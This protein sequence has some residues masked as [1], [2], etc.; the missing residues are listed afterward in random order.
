[1]QPAMMLISS[2]SSLFFTNHVTEMM[3]GALEQPIWLILLAMAVTPAI[4]EELVFR[5]YLQ[6]Q[7]SNFPIKQAALLNGL[8]FGIIHLNPQQFSYAFVLGIIFAY[9]VYYTRSIWAG[10]LPHFIF[11]ASQGLLGRWAFNTAAN[12]EPVYEAPITWALMESNPELAGVIVM[13]VITLF[14]SPIIISLFVALVKH[15][16]SRVEVPQI[17]QA[18]YQPPTCSEYCSASASNWPT[19]YVPPSTNAPNWT[20]PHVPP[21]NFTVEP[22]PR[23]FDKFTIAVIAIFIVFSYFHI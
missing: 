21:D 2:I 18:E 1:L 14:A 19:S 5:G 10:I 4:V 17:A 6:A 23:L 16:K 7:H 3:Y 8:F 15:N 11:N 22:P 12:P 13:A 9:M 20:T